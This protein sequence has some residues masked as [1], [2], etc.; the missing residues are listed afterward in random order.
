MPAPDGEPLTGVYVSGW[1]KRGPRGVIGSNRTD[2]QET[3]EQL[4][5]DFMAGKL[6]APG[7]DRAALQT[8]VAERQADLVDRQGW[9]SIDDAEKTAGK[10]AGRPRVKFT[11]REDL[12]KA[13]RG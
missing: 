3:V 10:S 5:A 8:L 7:A 1:I 9:K 12:L 4:I 13:A 6:A 2:S 11:T